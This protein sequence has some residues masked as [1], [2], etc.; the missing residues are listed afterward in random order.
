[1]ALDLAHAL[2]DAARVAVGGIDHHHVHAG[3]HQA[4]EPFMA[5][6]AGADGSAN[7]QLAD[8]VLGGFGVGVGLQDVLDGHETAQL[9]GVVDDQHAFETVLVHELLGVIQAGPLGHGDEPLARGHDVAHRLV[10]FGLEAQ[11]TVGDDADHLPAATLDHGQTGDAVL[12]GDG[13]DLAH[14]HLGGDG[15][16]VAHHA[17]LVALDRQDLGSLLLGLEVL[18][19]DADAAQ[20]GHD[21]GHAAFGDGIHRR[22]DERDVEA[23]FP[24]QAR[25]QGCVTG[26]EV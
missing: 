6:A 3:S 8:A 24:G 15:D 18:V 1:M 2:D 7:A 11:V 22:R 14:G 10:E 25:A 17:G 16:G 12:A 21:D 13:D 5:V 20:L 23:D 4:L 19:D 26:D 9:E